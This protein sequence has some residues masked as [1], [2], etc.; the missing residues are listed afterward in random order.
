MITAES[1]LVDLLA[2]PPP[3]AV[4]IAEI[5]LLDALEYAIQ[6]GEGAAVAPLLAELSTHPPHPHTIQVLQGQALIEHGRH[7]EARTPLRSAL[8]Q[9]PLDPVA[10]AALGATFAPAHPAAA[11]AF[12]RAALHATGLWDIP[13]EP[14]YVAAVAGPAAA[15]HA[16][17]NGQL[18]D[19]IDGFARQLRR[20]PNRRDLLIY[21]VET[22]RRAGRLHDARQQLGQLIGRQPMSL[23]LIWL[24]RALDPEHVP[25]QLI[26]QQYVSD[27]GDRLAQRFFAPEPP[28][29]PAAP[30]PTRMLAPR[31]HRLLQPYMQRPSAKRVQPQAKRAAAD[32]QVADLLELA[33]TR[34]ARMSGPAATAA[35][36]PVL[37]GNRTQQSLIITASDGLRRAIGVD[38]AR[39][40]L[41]RLAT[42]CH[43]LT[44]NDRPSALL[45]LSRPE[46]LVSGG[47]IAG[48]PFAAE[49]GGLLGSLRRLSALQDTAQ[50]PLATV[51]LV[52]GDSIIPFVRLPNTVPDGDVEIPS[53]LPYACDNPAQVV[54]Q[55]VVARL[56]DGGSAAAL[57]ALLEAMLA[58]HSQKARSTPRR[59]PW[60]RADAAARVGG[61]SAAAWHAASA[62][63]LAHAG[64]E[65]PELPTCPP[66][67]GEQAIRTITP[68]ALLYFNLHG[69]IGSANWYG[70]PE[71]P[72][73]ANAV[74]RPIAFTPAVLAKAQLAGTIV[75]SEACYGMELGARTV[76]Q[77][78][79]MSLLRQGAA[80]CVGSTV[81]AYGTTMPPLVGADL[82]A[83]TLLHGL[84]QGL[85]VGEALHNARAQLAQEMERR[86][87]YL[88]EID[89]KTL[90]SFVLYGDPW[91]TAFNTASTP[92]A[93]P[94][95]ASRPTQ[96]GAVRMVESNTVAPALMRQVRQRMAHLVSPQATMVIRATADGPAGAKAGAGVLTFSAHDVSLTPDGYYSAQAAHVTV[97]DGEIIKTVV[98]R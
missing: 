96:R 66:I 61:Y 43:V 90:N 62:A 39:Q 8:T 85:P 87:G 38:G 68:A 36:A 56:P 1:L 28:P 44:A 97:R 31:W 89:L 5:D 10:W 22:L 29:W 48:L 32:P 75:V 78:I 42:L 19:A 70:Q 76:E 30:M 71:E 21:Y 98:S 86:Q 53:D 40:V 9:H 91:A 24:L 6:L 74:Q 12:R 49:P 92:K 27:P 51:L 59:W 4:S 35:R 79:P 83:G 41:A 20:R 37:P 81:N 18:P 94:K 65:L 93:E 64:L 46:A 25:P 3:A 13:L 63:V 55:R 58:R 34:I 50:S 84:A 88:D 52:G 33:S 7:A 17:R 57:I 73:P 67:S 72:I 26:Q 14:Q 11:A 60:G 2:S 80:A 69:A 95:Q 23:P 77:S 16:L 45:D 15:L 82:L 54:P 47:G